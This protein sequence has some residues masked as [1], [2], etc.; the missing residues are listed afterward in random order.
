MNDCF[1]P[2]DLCRYT[3]APDDMMYETVNFYLQGS[4][5]FGKNII[6]NSIIGRTCMVPRK[7]SKVEFLRNFFCK[8]KS[9]WKIIVTKCASKTTFENINY[10]IPLASLLQK[11]QWVNELDSPPSSLWRLFVRYSGAPLPWSVPMNSFDYTVELSRSLGRFRFWIQS[12]D[13]VILYLVWRF[14]FMLRLIIFP[15]KNHH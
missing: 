12:S 2:G 14:S 4:A 13:S 15:P 5:L 9:E 10:G 8:T 7:L 1:L 3:G 11:L 6:L